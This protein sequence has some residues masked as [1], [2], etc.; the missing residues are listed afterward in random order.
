MNV[1][2]WVSNAGTARPDTDGPVPSPAAK[3]PSGP[4]PASLLPR[5]EPGYLTQ[6]RKGAK[7]Q[8]VLSFFASLRRCDFALKGLFYSRGNPW[9]SFVGCGSPHCAFCAIL[10]QISTTYCLSTTY[11]QNRA[12]PIKVN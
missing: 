3:P 10:Q 6:R 4:Q 12:F 7:T 11:N 8:S 5:L 9:F 2:H 1:G